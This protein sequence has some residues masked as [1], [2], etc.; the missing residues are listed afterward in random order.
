[1]MSV[2]FQTMKQIT[3]KKPMKKILIAAGDNGGKPSNILPKINTIKKTI[4]TDLVNKINKLCNNT[5]SSFD[6]FM[7]KITK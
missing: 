7:Q 4:P 3:N 1:M 6:N 2:K 5:K